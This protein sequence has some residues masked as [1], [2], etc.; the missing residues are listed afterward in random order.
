MCCLYN[1]QAVQTVSPREDIFTH[2]SCHCKKKKIKQERNTATKLKLKEAKDTSESNISL[3]I[4]LALV[5]QLSSDFSLQSHLKALRQS[6]RYLQAEMIQF[7]NKH[8]IHSH[9]LRSGYR[10]LVHCM[11]RE[12]PSS[13]IV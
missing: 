3:K 12:M 9:E 7:I 2:V 6:A 1:K 11:Y 4:A 8:N 10:F 13:E 5:Y